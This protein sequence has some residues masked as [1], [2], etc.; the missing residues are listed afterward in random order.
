MDNDLLIVGG[1]LIAGFSIPAI[2][3]AFS[4]NRFSRSAFIMVLVGVILFATALVL[5]GTPINGN[6][7]L[8]AIIDIPEA[9][10][11][12]IGKYIL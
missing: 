11:R 7:I 12:V 3:N 9:F 2:L 8:A 4:E 5:R 1:V 6:T 10:F